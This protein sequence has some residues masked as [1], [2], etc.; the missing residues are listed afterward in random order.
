MDTTKLDP[1]QQILFISL[2]VVA[3]LPGLYLRITGTVADPIV[4]AALYGLAIV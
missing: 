2:A 3:T 4:A 1:R